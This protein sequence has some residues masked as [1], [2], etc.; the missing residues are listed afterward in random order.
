MTDELT[1]LRTVK[2]IIDK[3]RVAAMFNMNRVFRPDGAKALADLLE[4]MAKRLDYAV[5]L[6]GRPD[7]KDNKRPYSGC[8]DNPDKA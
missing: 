4:E 3:C 5:E 6:V 1:W 8:P 2:P 7:D